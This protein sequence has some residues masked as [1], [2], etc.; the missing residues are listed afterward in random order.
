MKNYIY[1]N[2]WTQEL[3]DAIERSP[4]K[5]LIEEMF[6]KYGFKVM[7]M[8]ELK[9][10]YNWQDNKYEDLVLADNFIIT[11]DGYPLASLFTR[12]DGG[13]TTY[14]IYS[15]RIA[16][17][18]GSDERDRRSFTSVKLSQ[19]MKTLEKRRIVDD[20]ERQLNTYIIPRIVERISDKIDEGNRTK[21]IG[22]SERDKMESVHAVMKAYINNQPIE[23]LPKSILEVSKEL[24]D[25]FDKVDENTKAYFDRV[26][27][28]FS[29]FYLLYS[30]TNDGIIVS[31]HSAEFKTEREGLRISNVDET[32]GA[33]R[34]MDIEDHED[35]GDF[36]A[37]LTM[38]KVYLQEQQG[39]TDYRIHN[40]MFPIIDYHFKDFDIST[41]YRNTVNQFEGVYLCIPA[42]K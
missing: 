6:Y 2:L 26:R 33:V 41:Y 19:L 34:L 40:D 9:N 39:K 13:K 31:K 23:S 20:I 32:V 37:V 24:V 35:F 7:A 28:L 4:T 17:E 5:P 8:E 42:S 30:D 10:Q 15:P 22:Y 18:R 3:E 27:E 21:H 16:K 36:G 14:G 1:A 12:I 11:T 25:L 38:F 29:N